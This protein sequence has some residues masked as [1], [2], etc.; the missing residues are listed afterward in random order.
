MISLLYAMARAAAWGAA[1]GRL[2]AGNPRPL[3]KRLRNRAYLRFLER[4]LR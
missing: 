2:A 3:G 4:F 1:L